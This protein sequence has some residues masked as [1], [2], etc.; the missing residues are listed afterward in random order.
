MGEEKD[1]AREEGAGQCGHGCRCVGEWLWR[2][3]GISSPGL[4]LLG[5]LDLS[6][7][8]MQF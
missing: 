6:E 3:G 1:P 5:G 8:G 4:H 7:K 2:Q